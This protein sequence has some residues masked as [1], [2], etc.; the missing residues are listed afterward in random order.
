M[1]KRHDSLWLL[2]GICVASYH[3]NHFSNNPPRFDKAHLLLCS[4]PCRQAPA[5]LLMTRHQPCRGP[6]IKACSTPLKSR[7]TMPK[8]RDAENTNMAISRYRHP[9]R[10]GS[11]CESVGLDDPDSRN[12]PISARPGFSIASTPSHLAQDRSNIVAPV[13]GRVPDAGRR[14][15]THSHRSP[16]SLMCMQDSANTTTVDGHSQLAE[17]PLAGRAKPWS[18]AEVEH[19]GVVQMVAPAGRF[20]GC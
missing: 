10:S 20:T 3:P 14:P 12:L 9:C 19:G 1:L 6:L 2:L 4:T 18:E 16:T 11:D 5:E 8:A 17:I 13:R 7:A 15:H